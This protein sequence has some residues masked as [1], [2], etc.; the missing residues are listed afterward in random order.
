ML[1]T[2]PV[3]QRMFIGFTVPVASKLPPTTT[4]CGDSVLVS[5]TQIRKPP[6]ERFADGIC[7][8]PMLAGAQ[9]QVHQ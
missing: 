2:A 4:E 5:P 8:I 6:L 7:Q 1:A 3:N 9:A